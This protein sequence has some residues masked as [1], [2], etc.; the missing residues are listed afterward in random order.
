MTPALCVCNE[1][2]LRTA[3]TDNVIL[4]SRSTTRPVSIDDGNSAQASS[5]YFFDR[6]D[7]GDLTAVDALKIKDFS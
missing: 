3:R 2:H 6:V 4:E 1:P 7:T 5:A